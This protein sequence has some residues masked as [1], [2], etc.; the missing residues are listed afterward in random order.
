MRMIDS[1]AKGILRGMSG[2]AR[3]PRW[4]SAHPK[5]ASKAARA[6]AVLTPA[7]GVREYHPGPEANGKKETSEQARSRADFCSSR[8][9]QHVTGLE[10]VLEF[11]QV[12]VLDSGEVEEWDPQ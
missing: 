7:T 1:R 6:R 5:Q 9:V 3:A 11:D 10:T 12:V 2:Q 4:P 8:I